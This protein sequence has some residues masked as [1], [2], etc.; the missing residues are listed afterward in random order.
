MVEKNDKGQ[1]QGPVIEDE[2][3]YKAQDDKPQQSD[4]GGQDVVG[5][6][7]EETDYGEVI[8]PTISEALEQELESLDTEYQESWEL[9][10]SYRPLEEGE[11][12]KGF[13]LGFQDIS[14]K[15]G[16]EGKQNESGALT[17]AVIVTKDRELL[18]LSSPGLIGTLSEIRKGAAIKV[19]SEGQVQSGNN[20]TYNKYNVRLLEKQKGNKNKK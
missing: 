9:T 11:E 5:I 6:R 4:Q 17:T 18:L 10:A 20:R 7:R 19:S 2:A 1:D 16:T 12:V 15:Y 3:Q 14:A 8:V 13:F